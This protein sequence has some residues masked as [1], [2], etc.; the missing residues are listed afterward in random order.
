MSKKKKRNLRILFNSNA[1]FSSSGYGVH[2]KDILYRFIEDGW[3]VAQSTFYGLEGAPLMINGLKMYPKMADPWGSDAMYFH[4]KDFKADA[5][6]S[7]QDVWPMDTN[8]LKK[9][10]EEKIPW[11]PYVPIDQEPVPPLVLDKLRYAHKIITFSEFGRKALAKKGFSSTL[12][13]EGTDT[14]LFKP[15]DKVDMKKKLGIPED[16]FLFGMVG[17]NKDNPPRKGF[18]E[19]LDAFA[20]FVNDHPKSGMFIHTLMQQGGGF[21]LLDYA[22]HLGI[23]DKMY[24]VDDYHVFWHSGHDVVAKEMTAFDVLLQPS[25]NEGFG[26]PIIEAQSKGIPVIVNN[27]TAM[28]ELVVEGV[29]GEICDTYYKR[30]TGQQGYVYTADVNYLLEKMNKLYNKLGKKNTIAKDCRKHIIDNYNV[31]TIVKEKWIPLF[32]DLQEEL[33][34]K[35]KKTK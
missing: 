25:T 22:K 33:L 7:M 24:F 14:N 34:D 6:F 31:E 32:E 23:R 27:C 15:G 10:Q 12:I 3:Q 19:A 35:D 26:L 2:M 11:I 30:F 17:A 13:V 28:P 16:I 29:T 18:Q 8:F 4:G 9:M 21:P 20:L 1:A 5:V